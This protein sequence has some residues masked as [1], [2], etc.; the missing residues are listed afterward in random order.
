MRSSTNAIVPPRV[1]PLVHS[2]AAS[3]TLPT[4]QTKLMSAALAL[5]R[6]MNGR[7]GM[8]RACR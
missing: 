3:G 2:A 8:R 1:I 4:E 6:R 7:I 5:V